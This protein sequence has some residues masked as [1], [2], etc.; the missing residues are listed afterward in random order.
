MT[1]EKITL[2]EAPDVTIRSLLYVPT[3]APR[4][5]VIVHASEFGKSFTTALPLNQKV[6][7]VR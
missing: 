1:I 4:P 5:T 6:Q 2:T 3:A 7:T